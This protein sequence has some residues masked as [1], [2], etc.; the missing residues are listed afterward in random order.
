MLGDL[1]LS[2]GRLVENYKFLYEYLKKCR[3]RGLDCSQLLPSTSI[4]SEIQRKVETSQQSFN[5]LV[6]YIKSIHSKNIDCNLCIEVF[7]QLYGLNASCEEAMQVLLT[8]LAAWYIE[9]L[10]T[11]GL[12]KI[13]FAWKP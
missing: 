9:I 12:V 13:R 6:E 4:L 3:E 5:E 2:S 1:F 10:E 11:L 7:K 8:Q